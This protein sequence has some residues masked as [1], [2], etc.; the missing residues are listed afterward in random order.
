MVQSI[1]VFLR[2]LL[3]FK[4]LIDAANII[5]PVSTILWDSVIPYDK[6]VGKGI[7]SLLC[8]VMRHLLWAIRSKVLAWFFSRL[9]ASLPIKRLKLFLRYRHQ[10]VKI[11]I[12]KTILNKVGKVIILRIIHKHAVNIG[13][14][15]ALQKVDGCLY[16]VQ[17]V[18]GS[19]K[20]NLD[21]G[22]I[23]I[24]RFCVKP[25]FHI[26]ICVNTAYRLFQKFFLGRLFCPV[27]PVIPG[28]HYLVKPLLVLWGQLG[29]PLQEWDEH[30]MPQTQGFHFL[31]VVIFPLPFPFWDKRAGRGEGIFIKISDMG[32]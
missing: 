12:G 16:P 28:S 32:D 11:Q 10:I 31:S 18:L 17:A 19:L 27:K 2:F 25:K 5:I 8:R 24:V 30:V 7:G 15:A 29:V 1:G 20:G 4:R 26:T 6:W 23:R 3:S 22:Q 21:I 9:Y 14:H 13:F